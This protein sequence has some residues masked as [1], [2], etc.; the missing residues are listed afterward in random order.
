MGPLQETNKPSEE[1][2]YFP[3]PA[4]CCLNEE[5]VYNSNLFGEGLEA[6]I[7]PSLFLNFI[8]HVN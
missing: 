1:F 2:N 5:K 7:I 4:L 6:K 3:S 8:L